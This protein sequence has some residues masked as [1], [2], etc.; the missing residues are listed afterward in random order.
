MEAY[1][2]LESAQSDRVISRMHEDLAH[3]IVHRNIIV[4]QLNRLVLENAQNDSRAADE[5][6]RHVRLSI[7]QSGHSVVHEQAIQEP[8]APCHKAKSTSG[9]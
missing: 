7:R 1:L 4:L 5:F 8:H 6:I 9:M 3:K 2:L